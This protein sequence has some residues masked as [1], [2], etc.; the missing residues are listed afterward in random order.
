MRLALRLGAKD[1][2]PA[3]EGDTLGAAI[4]AELAVRAADTEVERSAFGWLIT[5]GVPT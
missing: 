5:L 3:G 4:V 1:G 2:L